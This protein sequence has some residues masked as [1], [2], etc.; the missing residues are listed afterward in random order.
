MSETSNTPKRRRTTQGWP[1][2]L[3]V[4][5]LAV[6]PYAFPALGFW[7]VLGLLVLVVLTPATSKP[8][9]GRAKPSRSRGK[10]ESP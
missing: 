8:G 4:C 6:A 5:A 7:P 10:F 1:L 9:R 3:I 2:F